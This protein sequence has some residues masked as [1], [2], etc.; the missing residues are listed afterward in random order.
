MEKDVISKH[1]R[2]M[3]S[4]QDL[5]MKENQQ[6]PLAIATSSYAESVERKRVKH[7]EMFQH[8][9]VIVT[10]DDPAIQNGKPAPDITV[11]GVDGEEFKLSDITGSGKHVAL[12]FSRAHWWPFCNAQL[13]ELQKH[14]D[15]FKKLN[16]ELVFVPTAMT[17]VM[18]T[19]A[20]AATMIPYSTAVAPSS[21]HQK[22]F[23]LHFFIVLPFRQGSK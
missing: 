3:K 1:E 10:G 2:E 13:V 20:I 8:F 4:Q 22:L 15:D 11:T 17:M 7:E 18:I 19:A 21:S 14:A 6:L 12:M 23:Q 9:D 5:L 16:A